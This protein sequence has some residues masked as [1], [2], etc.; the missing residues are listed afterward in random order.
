MPCRDTVH[1]TAL[2][3]NMDGNKEDWL[4]EFIRETVTK[5]TYFSEM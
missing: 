3:G 5:D 1:P 2:T 4:F